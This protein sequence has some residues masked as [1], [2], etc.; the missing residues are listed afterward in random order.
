MSEKEEK[1]WRE[2][3]EKQPFVKPEYTYDDYLRARLQNGL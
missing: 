3:H 1:Y 2:Q